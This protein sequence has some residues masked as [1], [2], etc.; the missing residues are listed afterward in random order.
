MSLS[1]ESLQ[2]LYQ[3]LDSEMQASFQR[4]LPFAEYIFDRFE[5]AKALAAGKNSSIHHLSYL[6]GQVEIGEDTWV[7]PLT[8]LDGSGG[9]KIGNNCSI[10]AGVHIYTHDT[11]KKRMSGGK[12]PGEKS[13]VA[14][15]N[16]CYIGPQSLISRGL[17]LGDSCIVGA[18]SFVTKSFPAKS[19]VFGNPAVLKGSVVSD[20]TGNFSIKWLPKIDLQARIEN[21]EEKIRSLEEKLNERE[22]K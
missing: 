1:K 3:S 2:K 9:L 13:P 12:M 4:S 7:G 20:A 19:V 14:I 22:R 6:Y 5:R 10:S 18:N 17:S 15:G 21:L 8:V 16:N 11:V